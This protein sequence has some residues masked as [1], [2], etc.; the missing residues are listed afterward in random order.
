MLSMAVDRDGDDSGRPVPQYPIES[1]DNALRILLQ[2]A[3]KPSLRMT[4]VSKYLGVATSTAHRLLAMLQYRGFV[5]QNPVT[6]EY[7]PD[8]SLTTIAFA[9][10]KHVDVR[11]RAHPIL[12][13]LSTAL[14]ETVHLGRLDGANVYFLDSIES[15][16]A[17]RV[18]SRL[19]ATLPAHCTSTGKALLATCSSAQIREFY[20][21]EKLT[22]MTP[23]SISTRTQLE[24]ELE[25]VRE[26]GYA[27]S[28]E[29]SEEGVASVSVA[30]GM[31]AT[32][33]YAVN[34]STP[35]YRMNDGVREEFAAALHEAAREIANLFA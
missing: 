5:R 31:I 14:G 4:E 23:S 7:E 32:N 26:R 20:P 13:K 1:V 33:L 30:I 3:E 6:K 2:L 28:R 34:V 29:E 17:V 18:G 12:E 11:D 9:V 15:T 27:Y 22:A 25:A 35:T 19:G 21:R 24:K 16:R 10:M 8:T